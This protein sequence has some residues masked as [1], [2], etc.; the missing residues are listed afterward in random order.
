MLVPLFPRLAAVW[1]LFGAA[2]KLTT[3][4]PADLP[5]LVR[6]LPL[7][8]VLTYRAVLS[9]E[10]FV[11]TLA[12]LAP[13]RAWPLLAALLLGFALVLT[14]HLRGGAASCGCLGPR[15]TIPTPLML[16]IDLVMLGLLLVARPWR[17][18]TPHR[19]LVIAS[20]VLA[21]AAASVPWWWGGRGDDAGGDA[22]P[23]WIDLHEAT[24]PG[25]RVRD[26]PIADLLGA[27]ADMENGAIV[28]WNASCEDCAHHLE[29]MA[30]ERQ[31]TPDP[32]DLVLIRMRYLEDGESKVTRKPEGFGVLE[33]DAPTR[34][35]WTVVPP[36]HVTVAAGVV[37]EVR[38]RDDLVH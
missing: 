20:V 1:V 6:G 8:D 35:E 14:D 23:R 31:A 17:A 37:V 22:T 11:G 32:G 30:F 13:R 7:D 26:L 36:L 4:S 9:I 21:L 10:F 18:A 33:L 12:L 19:A 5:A 25:R 38:R 24:W 15:F 16:G 34:P 2:L 27:R 28:L 29:R 3:G